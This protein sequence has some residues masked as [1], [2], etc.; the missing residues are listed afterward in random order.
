MTLTYTD[1]W[2]CARSV[3]LM[4]T[5]KCRACFQRYCKKCYLEHEQW[6]KQ[7]REVR[8]HKKKKNNEIRKRL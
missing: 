6:L 1:C 3:P 2:N 4:S 5:T 7:K 8:P